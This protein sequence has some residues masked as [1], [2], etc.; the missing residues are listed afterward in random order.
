MGKLYNYNSCI[1]MG[2]T[3]YFPFS[4]FSSINKAKR[5]FMSLLLFSR[6]VMSDSLRPHGLQHTTLPCPSPSPGVF[7]IKLMSIESV[8]PSN[9]SIN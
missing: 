7:S 8:M 1:I 3:E 9:Q 5:V 2:K 6:S 4:I